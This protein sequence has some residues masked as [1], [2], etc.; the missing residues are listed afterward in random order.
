MKTTVKVSL[1][2]SLIFALRATAVAQQSEPQDEA[3]PAPPAR[4]E[5]AAAGD[6]APAQPDQ[7]APAPAADASAANDQAAAPQ[8][9]Q[10]A[11][12]EPKLAAPKPQAPA[13]PP[14]EATPTT[15]TTVTTTPVVGEGEKGLRLNFRG[16]PLEMVLN[17]LSDAAGFTIVS[18]VDV[19][20]KVDV[21]SNQPLT[22]D[23]AVELLNTMLD[24]NGYAA[25]RNGRTLKIVSRDEAKKQKIPVESGNNPEDIPESDEMVTQIIPVRYAN[26]TQLTRDLQPLLPT[27]A[28]MTAN[29]SANALV[30]TDTQAN[31]RRMVEI[32]KALD[33]SIS[34]ISTVRVFPLR[35]ADA[36]E[37]ATAVRE[38]FQPAT[39]QQGGGRAQQFLNQ[40][41]QGRGGGPGGFGGGGG[42]G[43]GGGGTRTG[44][45]GGGP[46]PA[47]TR[48]V[49]V[50][51]ER[52]NSLI[53]SAP[54]D[55]MP[56]IEKLVEEIDVS[57]SDI[58]ELRVFRLMNADPVEMADLFASLFPD[59]TRSSTGGDQGQG[60]RFGGGP[61]GGRGNAARG[62][63][64]IPSERLKKKGR[65]LAV[66]DQRTSS[67]IVSAAS[68]LMPQIAEMVAQL[69][70]SPAKKQKVFVY[71]LENA[72][73]NEVE[74]ILRDMFDRGTL[75]T[76]RNRNTQNQESA[77]SN[78]SRQNQQN[79]GNQGFGTGFGNQGG[80]GGNRG[81][82]TF[83]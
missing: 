70:A 10:P 9:P 75:T 27:D 3:P 77:L 21:W 19:K 4:A 29:E 80:L 36:K 63:Q 26:A 7:D 50:A 15:T 71:S 34:S 23:E 6:D 24:Q 82:T 37:L 14:A 64:T 12:A 54:E 20:G 16:V 28:T 49:A 60:F 45:G 35:Y 74:Q 42:G 68:E 52:T 81:Q 78:R 41:L 32:V 33:T 59:E 43:A 40:F 56:T 79:Q 69:D 48:V 58:T 51:D 57:S 31:I 83:R 73:P 38:L 22:K 55:A 30:I 44:T 13:R 53:V 76:S 72:D 46:N 65:V 17:Y 67:I 2:V 47:A 61:F 1:L 39:T 25:I 66:P 8:E 62:Q 11:P 5:E 18:K